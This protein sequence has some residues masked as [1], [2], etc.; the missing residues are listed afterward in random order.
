MILLSRIL[1]KLD[2]LDKRMDKIE[3]RVE[4]IAGAADKKMP[5]QAGH[6]GQGGQDGQDGQGG[7][8]G[9]GTNDGKKKSIRDYIRVPEKA[10]EILAQLHRWIDKNYRV[11]A[12]VYIKAAMNA[13][14]MERPPYI[15]AKEEFPGHLGARGLYY[16]YTNE[17]LAFRK[18]NDLRELE[19]AQKLLKQFAMVS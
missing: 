14:I 17:P 11:K 16:E 15:I 2:Q 1:E 4:E 12:L 8:D 9:L 3:T 5:G 18:A 13:N 7:Q 19:S 6:D 10:E